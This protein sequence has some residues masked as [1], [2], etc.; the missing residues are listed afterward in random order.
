M[1]AFI[2]RHWL[3]YIIGAAIAVLIGLGASYFLGVK[4]STPADVRA[5]HV[6]AEQ[7]AQAEIDDLADEAD[8]GSSSGSR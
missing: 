2:Q 7:K 5:A 1:F 4:W 8:E 6:E 3:A